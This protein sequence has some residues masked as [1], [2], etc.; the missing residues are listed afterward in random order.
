MIDLYE[1]RHTLVSEYG[2][3]LEDI[4][5]MS[6]FDLEITTLMIIRHNEEKKNRNKQ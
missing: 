6:T 5:N 2:Y 3:S 1:I 4:D